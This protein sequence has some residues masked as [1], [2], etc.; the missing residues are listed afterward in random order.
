MKRIEKTQ[1]IIYAAMF[2]AMGM[3]LPL[4]TAQLKEIGDSL[5]PMHLAVMLCSIICGWKYGLFVGFALP[6]LRS[7]VFGM[8]ILYPNAVWMSAELATYGFLMGFLYNKFF[9]QQ[10]WWLFCSMT[11]T[12]LAGRIV[13]GISKAYLLGLAGRTLT[14]GGFIIGGFVDA[15][16]G[17]VIQF[18]FIP[19]IISIIKKKK[20]EDAA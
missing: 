5:L 7:V 18:V 9:E 13:W 19:A 10:T 6:L 2:F 3:I 4:L 12:M 14:L 17:I 8:P 16:F 20:Q 11:I 1:K 15:L